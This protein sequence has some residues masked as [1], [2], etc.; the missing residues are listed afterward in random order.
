M[1]CGNENKL[2]TLVVFVSL[3]VTTYL[4]AL[5][6]LVVLAWLDLALSGAVLVRGKYANIIIV[7]S[8]CQRIQVRDIETERKKNTKR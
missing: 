6:C 7:A 2:L 8:S 1:L 4:V 3:V 5:T